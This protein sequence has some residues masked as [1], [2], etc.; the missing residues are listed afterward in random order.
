MKNTLLGAASA[1]F[2][3]AGGA[4]LLGPRPPTS[5]AT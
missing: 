5:P 4:A 3:M 2:L 1:L